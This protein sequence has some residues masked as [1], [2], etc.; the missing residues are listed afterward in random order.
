MTS[1]E[2]LRCEFGSSCSAITHSSCKGPPAYRQMS[3]IQ[4]SNK[5]HCAQGITKQEV[6]KVTAF[7]LGSLSALR[8]KQTLPA[9]TKV[10]SKMPPQNNAF[11]VNG[12]VLSKLTCRSAPLQTGLVPSLSRQAHNGVGGIGLPETCRKVSSRSSDTDTSTR[13]ES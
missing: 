4:P 13:R 8:F 12:P 11:L 5:L 7:H 6:S 10:P 9:R 2:E 3:G 1:L